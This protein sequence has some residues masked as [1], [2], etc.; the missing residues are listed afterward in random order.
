MKG[1]TN[2]LTI[3][4]QKPFPS[5]PT[6]RILSPEGVVITNTTEDNFTIKFTLRNIHKVSLYEIKVS[7]NGQPQESFIVQL[8]FCPAC[9]TLLGNWMIITMQTTT[10][11]KIPFDCCPVCGCTFIPKRTLM[12]IIQQ[13]E[14]SIILPGTKGMSLVKGGRN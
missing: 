11:G 2:T 1:Q 9:K 4:F 13:K 10:G 6:I 5:I 8:Q 14:S 3:P 12:Q 7:I